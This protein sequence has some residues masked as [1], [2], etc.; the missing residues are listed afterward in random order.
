VIL[1]VYELFLLCKRPPPSSDIV[2]VN[3]LTEAGMPQKKETF[4]EWSHLSFSCRADQVLRME[5]LVID[6]LCRNSIY[7]GYINMYIKDAG[8]YFFSFRKRCIWALGNREGQQTLSLRSNAKC[9][10]S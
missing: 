9:T 1:L 7:K 3:V 10:E 2:A 5:I 6:K 4:Q 8:T